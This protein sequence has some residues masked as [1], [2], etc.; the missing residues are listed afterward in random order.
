[1]SIPSSPTTPV[2]PVTVEAR[3]PGLCAVFGLLTGGL[4]C[5]YWFWVTAREMNMAGARVPPPWLMALPVINLWWF[6]QWCV[7]V[8]RYTRRYLGAGTA[9]IFLL[10]VPA[11]QAAGLFTDTRNEDALIFGLVFAIASLACISI[12][13]LQSSLNRFRDR[14]IVE[15]F[16]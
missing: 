14:H 13:I 1:M 2:P 10:V 3:S 15:A 8:E 9:L 6:W 4:Y 12:P 5:L 7:G 16:E 11:S